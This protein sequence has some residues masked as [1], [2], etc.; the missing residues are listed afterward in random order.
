M[1]NRRLCL[2]ICRVF[3]PGRRMHFKFRIDYRI[4][5]IPDVNTNT[6]KLQFGFIMYGWKILVRNRLYLSIR[7]NMERNQLY[8][9]LSNI[10]PYSDF[11]KQWR[12]FSN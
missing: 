8:H 12:F 11:G 2:F 10:Y 6:D 1:Q 9:L 7:N 5:L 3:M 4:L